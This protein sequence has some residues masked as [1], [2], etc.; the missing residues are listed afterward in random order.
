MKVLEVTKDS[1]AIYRGGMCD[2][3]AIALH[4]LTKLPLGAWKGSYIDDDDEEQYEF[5]HVCIVLSFQNQ[6]WVDV[7]GIHSERANCHFTF[8]VDK[9]ELVPISR[10]DAAGL[11]TMEGVSTEDVQT[12]KAFIASD[13]RLSWLIGTLTFQA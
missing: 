7:D 10:Q 4:D 9:I 2:A 1:R 3:M 13:P 8:P 5:C 6:E 11:F 12:A